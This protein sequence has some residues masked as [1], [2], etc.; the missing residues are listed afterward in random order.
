[1]VDCCAHVLQR[2]GVYIG[3]VSALTPDTTSTSEEHF[4]VE[5]DS[6]IGQLGREARIALQWAVNEQ[7]WGKLSVHMCEQ[8]WAM[9][10]GGSVPGASVLGPSSMAV[11]K[12]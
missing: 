5:G 9:Q 6:L 10:A 1:M 7:G 4:V 3:L 2:R 12:P 11:H 8:V